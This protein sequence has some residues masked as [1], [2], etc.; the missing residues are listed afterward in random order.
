MSELLP[1]LRAGG[2][3]TLEEARERIGSLVIYKPFG[4]GMEAWEEG[5]ITSVNDSYVFVRFRTGWGSVACVP[6]SLTFVIA[7]SPKEA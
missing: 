6:D 7:V 5:T 2:P 3:V 4:Q 1:N